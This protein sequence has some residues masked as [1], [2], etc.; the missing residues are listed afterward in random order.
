VPESPA[1]W[2][3]RATWCCCSRGGARCPTI[4]ETVAVAAPLLAEVAP[5]A[6]RDEWLPRIAPGDAIVAVRP[7]GTPFVLH[8]DTADLIVVE[9][10]DCL[11]AVPAHTAT[12]VR[13]A[14][15]D[16]ARPLFQVDGNP[17]DETV[18][19]DG[20]DGWHAVNTAFDRGALGTAAQ[21]LGLAE[22][23]LTVT[24]DYVQQRRQFGVPIGSFQAVKHHL[25]DAL[26]QLEFAKP[27]VYHAA[28]SMAHG[29]DTRSRDVSMAKAYASDAAA[30]VAR[31]AL[32]CHGAIGYTVE[33][34][35]HVAQAGVGPRR[36][37]GRRP[38]P[39]RAGRAVGSGPPS[40]A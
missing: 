5:A 39:P 18:L 9:R 34:P 28:Y 20:P 26:L 35:P 33:R 37:L 14:S 8:A 38:V 3:W 7:M 23:L 6:F 19:V 2:A 22:H 24:V 12:L 21:L 10:D 16:G 29:L 25:A 31:Q 36:V 27:V 40:V 30:V 32:Q 4:V 13:Q 15:V 11:V 17:A 1:A